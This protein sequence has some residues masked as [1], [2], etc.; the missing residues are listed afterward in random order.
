[1]Q[2]RLLRQHFAILACAVATGCSPKPAPI[3]IQV[4]A[5]PDKR[6]AINKPSTLVWAIT[7]WENT[8]SAS[9]DF[10]V[11]QT[12]GPSAPTTPENGCSS[13][14]PPFGD[15]DRDSYLCYRFTPTEPGQYQFALDVIETSAGGR[16]LASGAVNITVQEP[17][18]LVPLTRGG[19]WEYSSCEIP[20]AVTLQASQHTESATFFEGYAIQT[21]Q[22]INGMIT[23]VTATKNTPITID[24][25]DD[26]GNTRSHSLLVFCDPTHEILSGPTFTPSSVDVGSA[27]PVRVSVKLAQGSLSSVYIFPLRD[28]GQ[29]PFNAGA[30]P[31]GASHVQLHDDGA[32]EHGDEVAGDGVYG[33]ILP[34]GGLSCP[35]S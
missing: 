1:M 34:T 13:W 15:P 32:S 21:V 33:A 18:R 6:V 27:E 7:G 17:P 5:G 11:R 23:I 14:P 10:Q 35:Q 4:I 19:T 22:P 24:A 12:Y 9:I 3:D 26:L 29:D 2:I 25:I 8:G 16:V 20:H 30:C 28:P 31:V